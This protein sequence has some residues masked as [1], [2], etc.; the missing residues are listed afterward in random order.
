MITNGVPAKP[1]DNSA[2][3]SKAGATP[4]KNRW[5]RAQAPGLPGHRSPFPLGF[6]DPPPVGSTDP[7][8]VLSAVAA[9]TGRSAGVV[10]CRSRAI[11]A[12]CLM[13][14]LA[15]AGCS[16]GPEAGGPPARGRPGAHS[17]ADAPAQAARCTRHNAPKESCFICD[18]ALREKGRLWCREHDRYED[19]CWECHPELREEGR[20]YCEAHGLYEDEC[21]LCRPE[22]RRTTAKAPVDLTAALFCREHQVAE[23]DCGICHPDRVAELSPGQSLLVRLPAPE[24]AKLVG[25]QIALPEPARMTEALECPAELRFDPGRVVRVVAP[26]EGIVQEALVDLG[27]RVAQGEVLGRLWSAALAEAWARAVFTY[28]TWERE[29]R[30][31]AT[32]VSPEQDLQRAEAE[33]RAACQYAQTL[34]FTE[35]EIHTQA[36][37][38]EGP[39]YLGLRSP[40]AGEVLEVNAVRGTRVEAGQ[41]L[42][43]VVDRSVL[44]AMLSLPETVLPRLQWGQPVELEVAAWPDR[45]F[46]GRLTWISPEVDERTR[47]VRARAEVPNEQGLLRARMFARARIL[48]HHG[49]NAL[50]VPA[51]A[52]QRVDGRPVVF[53]ER[54]ED[55]F[56]VRAVRIGVTRD[57]RVEILEGLHGED[58][59]VVAG[60]F[61]LKSQLL[62]SRLGAGCV[63]D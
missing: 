30:L 14:V 45:T 52:V 27:S 42:F 4:W 39:V 25:V 46:A 48:T 28:Q 33:H 40:M 54:S 55:L 12:V 63:D 26:V 1:Q 7:E 5:T 13:G 35:S 19:R 43:T 15:V 9:L 60:G 17:P 22:L 50:A 21:F 53:V 31:R 36:T 57:G 38:P 3:A 8:P 24:S 2:G 49:S 6:H 10:R 32:R 20:D 62:V 59:V 56:E 41:P 29:R 18:P 34:G 47:L 16:K 23:L 51:A 37:G 61:P 11:L 58:R 44:W